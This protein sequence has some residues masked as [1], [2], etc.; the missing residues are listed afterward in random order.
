MTT[1]ETGQREPHA[2]GTEQLP[3]VSPLLLKERRFR[4]HALRGIHMLLAWLAF[5][6]CTSLQ[7]GNPNDV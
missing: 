6:R 7:A 5:Y 4:S 3:G 1:Q 2:L